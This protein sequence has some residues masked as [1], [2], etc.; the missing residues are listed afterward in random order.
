MKHPAAA[1]AE[2]AAAAPARASRDDEAKQR[3]IAREV[4]N[5]IRWLMPTDRT[6]FITVDGEDVSVDFGPVRQPPTH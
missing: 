4:S 6:V 5:E 1:P 2:S 3:A